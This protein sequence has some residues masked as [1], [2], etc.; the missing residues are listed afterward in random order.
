LWVFNVFKVYVYYIK[1]M[2]YF[3]FYSYS[4]SF[5]PHVL[6]CKSKKCNTNLNNYL[7]NPNVRYYSKFLKKIVV[8]LYFCD[9]SLFDFL[10][11]LRWQRRRHRRGGRQFLIAA[12]I[13]TVICMTLLGQPLRRLSQLAAGSRQLGYLQLLTIFV[14][15]R[16][17]IKAARPIYATRSPLKRSS[18]HNAAPSLPR[19][20]TN[21]C[22]CGDLCRSAVHRYI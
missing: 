13:I 16:W 8:I 9:C 12:I 5:A 7:F 19:P 21:R 1:K 18:R 3:S 20:S 14:A 22:G 4:K 2:K 15:P 17:I 6:F 11:L 10:A